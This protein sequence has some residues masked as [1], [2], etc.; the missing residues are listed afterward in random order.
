M[1]K[2]RK[3]SLVLII[4]LCWV[5]YT[6]AYIGRLNL[7]AY[8]EPIRDQL[9]ASKTELGL[10]SS[11]FFFSYGAGQLVHGILSKKY[12]TR[13]SV[14]AALCG[15]AAVNLAMALCTSPSAMKYIWL[16][17]GFFQSILW[18]SVIKTLADRLPDDMLPKAIMVMSTPPAIGTFLVYGMSALLSAAGVSY[19]TVFIIPAVLLGISG[20]A[21]FVLIRTADRTETPKPAEAKKRVALTPAFIFGAV[22]LCFAAISNGFIKDGVT[23]W[24]PSILKE[25]YGMKEALSILVTVILPLIAVIGAWFSTALHKIQKNTSVLNGSLYF[26]ESLILLFVLLQARASVK[27]P[28]LLIVLF[29]ISA[30][31]MSAVNNVIT[32]IIPLYMRDRAAPG[33]LAGVLDTFCYVGST[34]STGLLGY[35]SDK[36]SWNGVFLCLFIFGAAAFCAC[37]ISAVSGK[38]QIRPD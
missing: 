10:V 8:I 14:T 18:S 36:S 4:A 24:T 26:A 2:D 17:N 1:K 12:N 15:S 33:L 11:F 31:L 27:S 35:I 13:F 38:K 34:L 22:L 7:N 28:V 29:S 9:G 20:C 37:V 5:A 16:L 6:V 23:T 19:K 25:R 3:Q 32:S 30:M 21:W